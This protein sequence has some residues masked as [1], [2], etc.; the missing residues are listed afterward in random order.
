MKKIYILTTVLLLSML[1]YSCKKNAVQVIDVPIQSGAQ[2]KFFNFGINSPSVNFYANDSKL[3]ATLSATGAEST[4]GVTYGSVF[5][6]SNYTLLPAASYTFKG[7]IPSTATTDANLSIADITAN[8][9][10]SKYYTMYTCGFYN[11]AA[12]RSD[13][14]IIEDKLPAIDTS[15]AYVKFVNTIP[16]ATAAMNLVVRNTTTLAETIIATGIT[17]KSG[18]DYIKLP[19]AVYDMYIRYPNSA[20]SVISRTAFSFLKGRIYSISSRGDI[21]VVSTTATNR[22]LLDVTANR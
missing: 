21:T 2:I 6:A 16:N 9:E 4:T 17:Y 15:V 11:T 10:S 1:N 22:P 7:Q 12:K 20:T 18:S 5:P 3:S 8:V 19:Q 14:F 13:A